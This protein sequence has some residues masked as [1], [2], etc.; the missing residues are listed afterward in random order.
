[1]FL[2]GAAVAVGVGPAA[3]CGGSRKEEGETSVQTPA[4][5]NGQ[6][7]RGGT[8]R[9]ATTA[10]A[11]SLDPHSDATL[12]AVADMYMYGYAVHATDWGDGIYG[13]LA[14]SWEVVDGVNWVFHIRQ[15]ARF[16]NMPPANGR[17]AVAGDIVYSFNRLESIPGSNLVGW[18]DWIDRYEAPDDRTLTVHTT[19]PYA[20][21]LLNMGSPRMAVVPKEAVEVFGDLKSNAIGTGPF[22]LGSWDRNTGVEVERN[23]DYYDREVPYLDGLKWSVMSDDSAIQAAFR[24]GAIDL[25]GA[26]D[27]ARAESVS[28][29]SGASAQRFLNRAYAV[30]VLNA[31]RTPAFKDQRVR[32]AVDLALDRQAM[33]QRLFL[34]EAELCGPV[35]PS[36]DTALP[37]EEIKKAY[38]RDVAKSTQLLSAAGQ[39]S[40]SFKLLCASY[41]DNP[42][43]A[44]II[45]QN[46]KDA[47]ISVELQTE[48]LGTWLGDMY[49]VNYEADTFSHLAYLG[50]G[51]PLQSH[52]STGFNRAMILGITDPEVDSLLLQIQTTIDD[53]ARKQLAW[54]V[55]RKILQRHGPTLVLYEPYGYFVAYDY[56]KNYTPSPWIFGMYKY[57]MWLDRR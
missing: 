30:L 24:S 49:A 15:G 17:E 39:E 40:L 47:G 9:M 7:K 56:I 35:G 12:G 36:W 34:G 53:D 11:L 57:D 48:E 42:D 3:A 22:Q 6:P 5:G 26:P 19:Q 18:S 46:L 52:Y 37:A 23:P 50:D 28:S 8:I 45:Q 51:I 31:V 20:Y 32:E 2:T 55:Q 16:H 14:Q 54:E 27:K 25:Y 33:I 13:D 21:T 10:P 29:V 38:T 44:S 41:G 1:M 43:R 4:A